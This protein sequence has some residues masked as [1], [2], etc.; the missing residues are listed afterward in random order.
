MD[1]DTPGAPELNHPAFIAGMNLLARTGAGAIQ[2]RCSCD[3]VPAVWMLIVQYPNPLSVLAEASTN[4]SHAPEI[5]YETACGLGPLEA[6]MRLCN[7]VLA[8]STCSFCARS[9]RF[10]VF[11]TV[12][13][14]AAG[15]PPDPTVCVVEWDNTEGQFRPSCK[16]GGW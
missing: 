7:E 15:A 12:D 5:F 3:D 8:G 11:N 14:A 16:R 2:I 9:V 1:D 13:V 4:G 10:Q 6:V